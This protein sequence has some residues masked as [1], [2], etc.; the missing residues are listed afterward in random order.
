LG[1]A[2][3]TMKNSQYKLDADQMSEV[4]ELIEE[5]QDDLEGV[6]FKL[7][8]ERDEFKKKYEDSASIYD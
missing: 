3:N 6:L 1:R 4:N 8:W 2:P 5:A 7:I